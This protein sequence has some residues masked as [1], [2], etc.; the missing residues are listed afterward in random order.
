MLIASLYRSIPFNQA[1]TY[2][3]KLLSLSV[4]KNIP[5]SK[6]TMSSSDIVTK[7][8]LDLSEL[9]EGQMCVFCS[10]YLHVHLIRNQGGRS[11]DDQ[12]SSRL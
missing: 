6:R 10:A 9:K 11:A 4:Q 5:I 8:V 12:E 1:K 2:S 3:A 7:E